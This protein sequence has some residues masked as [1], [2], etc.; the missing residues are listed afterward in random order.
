MQQFS[1]FIYQSFG[2]SPELQVKVLKTIAVILV[3]SF[4]RFLAIKIL[5]RKTENIKI[6]YTWRKSLSYINLILIVLLISRI[7][8]QAFETIGTFLGLLS[9]GIAISLKDLLAN[10]AAW[11]FIIVRRPFV[12]GDRVQ[13]GE[14]AGDVVDIRAYM[15]SI[16]EI[17]NWVDADQSTGRIIHIPNALVFTQA[18]VNYTRGFGYLWNEISMVIT[19]E[20]N[21]QKAKQ[22][23]T[24]IADELAGNLS[25]Q[26]MHHIKES[27]SKYMIYYNK[28]TPIVY[29][30][31]IDNGVK[32]TIRYLTEPR[33]RR[34]SE[35]EFWERILVEFDHHKDISFA[36]PTHR[37]FNRFLEND[38]NFVK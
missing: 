31:V 14:N 1:E 28:L 16:L 22:L 21:W 35:E 15:F 27:A 23:L 9:A 30:K 6:R 36:Y 38:E 5:F 3:L 32:L 24:E 17:R 8:F 20:S 10:L 11:I 33:R 37:Y 2:L 12:L 26:A 13:V 4:F 7:W 18:V 29:L 34:G 25:E 19:F